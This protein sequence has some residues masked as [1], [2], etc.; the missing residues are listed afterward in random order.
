LHHDVLEG[1]GLAS[2]VACDHAALDGPAATVGSGEPSVERRAADAIPED[3][4]RLAE[5]C[6]GLGGVGL[7]VVK[8]R[9][10]AKGLDELDLLVGTG[11]GDDVAARGLGDLADELCKEKGRRLGVSRGLYAGGPVWSGRLTSD[12]AV[13]RADEDRLSGL[14]VREG[15]E[16]VVGGLAGCRSERPRSALRSAA[17]APIRQM[18]THACRRHRPRPTRAGSPRS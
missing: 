14:R 9:V 11:R 2:I 4:D 1:I 13:G 5:V 8:G 6:E 10:D 16:A 17:E 12:G 3:V 7:L 15:L 18:A